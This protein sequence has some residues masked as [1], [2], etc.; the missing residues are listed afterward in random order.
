MRG[1]RWDAA[2]RSAV[3]RPGGAAVHVGAFSALGSGDRV[4]L[5]DDSVDVVRHV[6]RIGLSQGTLDELVLEEA[7]V[8]R[9]LELVLDKA[10]VDEVDE[11]KAEVLVLA[12]IQA[13]GIAVNY[14]LQLLEHR[15]PFPNSKFTV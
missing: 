2:L 7:V 10:G 5:V 15:V 12:R 14:L 13:R 4:P 11:L 9:P 3:A 8:L 6:D 1:R